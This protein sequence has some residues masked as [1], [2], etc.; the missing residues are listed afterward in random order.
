MS[1]LHGDAQPLGQRLRI[2]VRRGGEPLLALVVLGV[3]A[4]QLQ[5]PKTSSRRSPFTG[6]KAYSAPRVEPV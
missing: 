6:G 3:G 2:G 5:L 1:E 4:D